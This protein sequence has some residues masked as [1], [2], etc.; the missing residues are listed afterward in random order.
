MNNFNFDEWAELYKTNPALFEI[1]RKNLLNSIINNAPI[2]H[3][4]KLRLI[5][6]QCDTIRQCMPPLAAAE[7]MTQMS[8]NKLK[9]LNE[10]LQAIKQVL[11]EGE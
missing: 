10:P 1:E 4:S 8:L 9:D 7:Q 6:L 3:R 5:Q 11:D 2:E